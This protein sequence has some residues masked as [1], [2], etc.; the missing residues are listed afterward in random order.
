MATA[1]SWSVQYNVFDAAGVATNNLSPG[2]AWT[3]LT[4]N[5]WYREETR[6]N[7]AT[8]QVIMVGITDLTTS[9]TTTFAPTTWYLN[10]GS[11]PAP[12][13]LRPNGVRMFAGGAAGNVFAFDN[14]VVP[15]PA[16]IVVLGLGALAALRRRSKRA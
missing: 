5:H 3:T 10:G 14:L 13:L 7:F 2:A 8:N 12:T 16:S 11:A 1:A 4:P 9:V 6:V 15:E